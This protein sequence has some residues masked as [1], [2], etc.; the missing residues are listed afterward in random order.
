MFDFDGTHIEALYTNNKL[1]DLVGYQYEEMNHLRYNL[2]VALTEKDCD[3]TVK[4]VKEA[5]KNGKSRCFMKIKNS[6]RTVRVLLY[7][8]LLV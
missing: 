4:V 5:I 7:I 1:Y 6:G 3:R 8:Y 2:L